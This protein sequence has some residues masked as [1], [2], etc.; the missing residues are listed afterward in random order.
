MQI[1][2]LHIVLAAVLGA[3][4][5]L[6][7]SWRPQWAAVLVLFIWPVEQL[8]QVYVPVFAAYGAL[9]NYVVGVLALLAVII[10]VSRGNRVAFG[11]LNG[12]TV[13]SIER[14]RG[15]KKRLISRQGSCFK[16]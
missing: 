7:I 11:I 15:F 12:S 13:P 16:T 6:V 2:M 3:A 1:S 10:R 9:F 8:M 14:R 4:G 5:L